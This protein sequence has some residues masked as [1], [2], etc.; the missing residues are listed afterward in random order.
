MR[1]WSPS[2]LSPCHV[3]ADPSPSAQSYLAFW[4]HYSKA[5]YFLHQMVELVDEP[6]TSRL[7][8]QLVDN[9]IQDGGDY[10]LACS[11]IQRFGVVP[12]SM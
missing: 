5:E 7:M 4:D 2:G 8:K 10:D 11:L 1:R 6:L 12:Q 3:E 9:S